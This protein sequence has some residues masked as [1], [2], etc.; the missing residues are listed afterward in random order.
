[1]PTSPLVP[2]CKLEPSSHAHAMS[3]IPCMPQSLEDPHAP[4]RLP[5]TRP[6]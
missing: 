4:S 2:S 6:D 3:E 1:M 5:P